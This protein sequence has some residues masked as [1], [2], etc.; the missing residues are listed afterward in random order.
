MSYVNLFHFYF[1]AIKIL[2]KSYILW[3]GKFL[4]VWVTTQVLNYAWDT[5]SLLHDFFKQKQF[6]FISELS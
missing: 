3:C 1:P 5:F 6:W 2:I 4:Q